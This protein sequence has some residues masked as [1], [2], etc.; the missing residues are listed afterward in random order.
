VSSGDL[1]E[2]EAFAAEASPVLLRA[3]YLLLRDRNEAQDAVQSTLLRVLRHWASAR[4]APEAYTQTVLLNICRDLW[5]HDRRHP[6]ERVEAPEQGCSARSPRARDTAVAS[7]EVVEQRE[8]LKEALDRLP[9]LQREVLVMRFFLDLP[10]VRTSELLGVPQGTVK[11]AT[12]RGLEHLRAFLEP[13]D[14]EAT[15]HAALATER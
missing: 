10:V 6:T 13:T 14:Q 1:E 2:F 12:S 15:N 4:A 11:S 3:A 8:L 9:A 5:K 7:L